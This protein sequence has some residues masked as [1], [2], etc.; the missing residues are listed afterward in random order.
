MVSSK[1]TTAS[2]KAGGLAEDITDT[3]IGKIRKEGF[4]TELEEK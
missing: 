3:T 2:T 4:D 1:E